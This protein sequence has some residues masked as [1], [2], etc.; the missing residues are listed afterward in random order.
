MEL[1][2]E[3]DYLTIGYDKSCNSIIAVWK[4]PATSEEFRTG[5]LAHLPAM[6]H[7]KTTKIISDTVGL[8]AI[9]PDDTQ[10]TIT[11]WYP[12]ASKIGWSHWGLIIPHDVFTQ[13]A[14]E[15]PIDN[16]VNNNVVQSFF[17][18]IETAKEW[19]KKF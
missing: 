1:Y 5:L 19:I 16:A 4:V 18:N 7:Y 2:F 15:D 3:K 11:D 9:H 12:Q 17:D 10:W 6:E 8:G 14:M 13:M